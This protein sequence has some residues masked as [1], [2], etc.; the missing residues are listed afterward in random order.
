ML[1]LPNMQIHGSFVLN[2]VTIAGF[3]C[4]I[5]HIRCNSQVSGEGPSIYGC[6][7]LREIKLDWKHLHQVK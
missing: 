3:I 4:G 5:S 1:G 7:L 2:V 6:D